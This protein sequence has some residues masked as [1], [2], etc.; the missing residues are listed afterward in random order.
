MTWE[1]YGGNIKRIVITE[2]DHRHAKLILVLRHM[3]ISQSAL[4]RHI[5][6]GMIEG[7][8]R[9]IEYVSEISKSSKNR[10]A[11][12]RKLQKKGEQ[13]MKDFNSLSGCDIEE[14]FDIIEG[15]HPLL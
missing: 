7:D 5:V 1:S 2:S 14:L 10:K 13:M 4:F 6:T 12:K 15:E 8:P 3:E 11:E 9:V